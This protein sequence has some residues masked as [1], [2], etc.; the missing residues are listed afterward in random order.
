MLRAGDETFVATLVTLTLAPG[1]TAPV[2]SSTVPVMVPRSDCAKIAGEKPSTIKATAQN[3]DVERH[4]FDMETL[5]PEKLNF[6][7]DF[8]YTPIGAGWNC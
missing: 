8:E 5:L 4:N 2:E 6:F 7:P 3:L 1:T